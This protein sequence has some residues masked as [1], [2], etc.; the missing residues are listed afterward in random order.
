MNKQ[1]QE[2]PKKVQEYYNSLR[3]EEVLAKI[4]HL[5]NME[6]QMGA[7]ESLTVQLSEFRNEADKRNLD[8][9]SL[10]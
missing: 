8:Y 4:K 9:K 6:K 5:T 2:L 10:L 1:K 3:D 7:T